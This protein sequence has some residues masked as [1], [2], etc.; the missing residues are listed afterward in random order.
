MPCSC[1]SCGWTVINNTSNGLLSPQLYVNVICSTLCYKILTWQS[2]LW[3]ARVSFRE[4]KNRRKDSYFARL[5][6]KSQIKR[7]GRGEIRINNPSLRGPVWQLLVHFVYNVSYEPFFAI[8]LGNFYQSNQFHSYNT[9]NSQAYRLP[10]CR[11][12]TKKFS[13]FFQG[14]KF[15]NSLDNEVI[16][17]Q[18]LS[19]FKKVLKIKLFRKYENRA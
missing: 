1:S 12:N 6:H 9:R 13:P 3:R 2:H 19:S 5:I 7:T 14:P 18:S 11:T 17:S 4:F 8:E 16:N 15:F 10:Y